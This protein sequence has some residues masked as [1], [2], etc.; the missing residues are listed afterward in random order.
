M[1]RVLN[2]EQNT[3]VS[4]GAI[5]LSNGDI[6]VARKI[7]N[8]GVEDESIKEDPNKK[9]MSVEIVNLAGSRGIAIFHP[10]AACMTVLDADGSDTR[11]V[12]AERPIRRYRSIYVSD[13]W[14]VFRGTSVQKAGP[15]SF[16]EHCA[17]SCMKSV[18][19]FVDC[20]AMNDLYPRIETIDG[21]R[22]V[23]WN[24][25][26]QALASAKI[27]DKPPTP[28]EQRKRVLLYRKFLANAFPTRDGSAM[29]IYT[30]GSHFNHSCSANARAHM[31]GPSRM[32]KLNV[33][34]LR[35]LEAGEEITINYLAFEYEASRVE[36]LNNNP[37]ARRKLL[38]RR[39]GFVCFCD[40][41]C[42]QV[43]AA[44]ESRQTI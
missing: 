23:L 40:L 39:Y 30:I 32:P 36:S 4:L 6:E 29:A 42:R 37:L 10:Y 11:I 16:L 22:E 27:S 26:S 5:L 43:M 21:G 24:M 2:F 35:D 14:L 31:T 3:L 44:A 7:A 18:N 19:P 8:R 38:E 13:P 33:Y 34:A 15:R 1:T 28:E 25:E 12:R 41:C 17:L 9:L 20:D